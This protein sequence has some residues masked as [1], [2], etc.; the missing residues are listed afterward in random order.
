MVYRFLDSSGL[1]ADRKEAVIVHVRGRLWRSYTERRND[2][3]VDPV[4]RP[5]N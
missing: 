1:Q 2:I 4:L 3:K 5:T